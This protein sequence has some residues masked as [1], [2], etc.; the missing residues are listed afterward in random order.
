MRTPRLCKEVG[1]ACSLGGQKGTKNH[2]NDL[3]EKVLELPCLGT[4]PAAIKFSWIDV[5]PVS[6]D[7]PSTSL[8]I[9]FMHMKSFCYPRKATS[10]LAWGFSF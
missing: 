6:A 3:A 1:K 5:V 2:S 9:S 8:Q 7:P 4:F 10:S